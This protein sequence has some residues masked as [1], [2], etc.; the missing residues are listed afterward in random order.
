L[1]CLVHCLE[2]GQRLLTL[3]FLLQITPNGVHEV[4]VFDTADGLYDCVWSEA[5]E[6]ILLAASGDGSV[7]MY[8]IAAPPH[9]NPLRSFHEH[10]HEVR[11]AAAYAHACT[12]VPAPGGTVPSHACQHTEATGQQ[13]APLPSSAHLLMPYQPCT[14]AACVHSC[15]E[16]PSCPL[17][18]CCSVSWNLSKRDMFLS[19]SWD[20]SIK[21]WSM[22]RP[23]S[24]QTFMGHSYCVYQVAWWVRWPSAIMACRLN[25]AHTLSSSHH[26]RGWMQPPVAASLA[27][28][29]TRVS[30]NAVHMSVA[31]VLPIQAAA[32]MASHAGP[33]CHQCSPPATATPSPSP[34]AAAALQA[35]AARRR[36]PVSLR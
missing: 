2:L 26:H 5:N 30:N 11:P 35:P 18:Q 29:I 36:V 4:A 7:K 17:L 9:A 20:D 21:L 6:N 3:P 8:D 32:S 16:R 28:C 10:K 33:E 34:V 19:S 14:H 22:E 23:M 12:R 15:P 27:S 1:P 25:P 13:P 24:M 31:A